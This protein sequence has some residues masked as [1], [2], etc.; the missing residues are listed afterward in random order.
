MRVY[1]VHEN[2]DYDDERRVV[3]VKE[4]FCWPALFV[5]I[6]WTIYRRVWLG[7]GVYLVG[8][9]AVGAL[10]LWLM[11]QASGFG[12]LDIA[13]ALVVGAVANDFRRGS[14]KRRGY[15]EVAVV[16]GETLDDAERRWFGVT[17]PQMLAVPVL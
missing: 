6:I 16:I 14:L 8:L 4:G 13:Y 7:L 12:L 11:P 5:T 10:E 15:R 17:A 1:T 9:I 3:L 2:S